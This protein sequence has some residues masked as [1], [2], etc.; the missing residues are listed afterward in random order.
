MET[1]DYC[2]ICFGYF[3]LNHSSFVDY[4]QNKSGIPKPEYGQMQWNNYLEQNGPRVI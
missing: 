3:I 2:T 1:L 4:L